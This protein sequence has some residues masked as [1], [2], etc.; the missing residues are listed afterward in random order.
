L[1]PLY[2]LFPRSA[3]EAGMA[4][5][6]LIMTGFVFVIGACFG[7]FCSVLIWRIPRRE[8]IVFTPSHCP[9]C[10]TALKSYYNIPIAGWLLTRGRCPN[11]GIKVPPR[12]IILEFIMG[13]LFVG[14]WL[15][16]TVLGLP[17]A[18]LLPYWTLILGMVAIA[19]IDIDHRII[20]DPINLTGLIVGI[21]L[22]FALPQTHLYGAIDD[23]VFWLMQH[24]RIT[25]GIADMLHNRLPFLLDSPRA[26]IGLDMLLG[27]ALGGG[28]LW[29]FGEVGKIVFGRYTVHVD[30]PQTLKVDAKGFTAGDE[31]R[32]TWYDLF[33]RYT[34]TMRVE[35]NIKSLK[36][37]PGAAEIPT[38]AGETAIVI[39]EETSLI[40]DQQIAT[41]TIE[42]LEIEASEW[43]LPREAMGLGDVKLLAVVG[44]FLGPSGTLFVLITA[45]FLGTF[46]GY[47]LKFYE[48]SIRKQPYDSLLPFGA[49][50]AAATVTCLLYGTELKAMF[51]RALIA[52]L[53][54]WIPELR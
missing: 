19:Y 5:T 44:V 51:F 7:S 32:Q 28:I 18:V 27:V 54:Q 45:C 13:T 53:R 11:C 50:I 3:F 36:L 29:L 15:R 21:I 31:E 25:F 20:P 17:L 41:E 8:E 16:V 49:Y 6:Y 14:A 9:G 48:V 26:F 52:V 10:D 33:C 12:Y 23:E 46:V 47:A 34:D 22:G 24:Q 40:G 43:V 1:N 30:E 38:S 2:V 39:G 35:G 42:L 4:P 37:A